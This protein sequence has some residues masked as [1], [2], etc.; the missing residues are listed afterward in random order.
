VQRQ[1]RR[2]DIECSYFKNPWDTFSV[3]SIATISWLTFVS[4]GWDICIT[5][6]VDVIG[7][8]VNF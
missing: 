4:S 6:H 3:L 2:G 5:L 1:R 8:H 7:G